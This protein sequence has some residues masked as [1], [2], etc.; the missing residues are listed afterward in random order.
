LYPL[1]PDLAEEDLLT[2]EPPRSDEPGGSLIRHVAESLLIL[3]AT[4][5]IFRTF[6]AEGYLISTGSMAPT[7]LGYHKQVTCPTCSHQFA[8]GISLEEAEGAQSMA[9]TASASVASPPG[10]SGTAC[11]NCGSVGLTVEALP[12][13]EGDQLL[14][15]KHAFALRS[16]HRWEVIVFRNPS[17]PLEAYVKRVV[18][19][20]GEKIELRGGEVYAN[21]VRQRKPL[22]AQ[23]GTRIL[24]DEH[25]HQP[26]S[27]NEDW[28]PRWSPEAAESNWSEVENGFRFDPSQRGDSLDWL[29]FRH[30]IVSGGTHRSEIPLAQW[31][32][33]LTTPSSQFSDLEYDAE[34]KQ[35][36]ITGALTAAERDRWLDRTEDEV[37]RK[38][39]NRLYRRSHLAPIT[40]EYGYNQ[41]YEGTKNFRVR[42]LM[43]EFTVERV[44]DTGL[45]VVQLADGAGHVDFQFDFPAKQVRVVPSSNPSADRLLTLPEPEAGPQQILVSIFD[46]QALVAI[47]E[48]PIGEPLPL[49]ESVQEPV[50][51]W[52]ERPARLGNTGA[53]VTVSN[54]RLYRDVYYTPKNAADRKVFPLESNEYFVLGDNSPVS[55]DSRCWEKPGVPERSLIGKPF[56]VHLPS[57]PGRV[58]WGGKVTYVRVPD[59][60]RVRYIH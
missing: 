7:L 34:R 10:N 33:E 56:V 35:L 23:L 46:G 12:K 29:E 42:D 8:K 30:W 53:G 40:D 18:G 50:A 55:V 22:S 25:Q 51:S 17:E 43:L 13:N 32:K 38:T 54:L 5:L 21:G 19:L 31:P 1:Q 57:R 20:P 52:V 26:D 39:L 60:S 59:F 24:V 15:N 36:S 6:A 37:F 27:E 2:G 3:A 28:E 11:P 41:R 48:T 44:P 4:V 14:V 47:D 9:S 45:L 49:A 16:P 58:A